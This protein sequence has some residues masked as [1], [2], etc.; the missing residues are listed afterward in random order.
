[1]RALQGK[2]S[3]ASRFPI[4]RRTWCNHFCDNTLSGY[5][6]CYNNII[7]CNCNWYYLPNTLVRKS[8]LQV[9]T[10]MNTETFINQSR[11]SLH[12]NHLVCQI[13][14]ITKTDRHANKK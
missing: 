9:A 13:V 5:W 4:T 8:N 1:M 12:R 2:S 3:S 10:I 7:Y 14:Q 6:I 11:G